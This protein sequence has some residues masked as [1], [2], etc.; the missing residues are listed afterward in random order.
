M[1]ERVVEDRVSRRYSSK[2]G[3]VK[4]EAVVVVM[5]NINVCPIEDRLLRRL[6]QPLT[7]TRVYVCN[8]VSI[9]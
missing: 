7:I 4:E 9:T 8:I 3:H 5:A 1:L 2:E 6:N